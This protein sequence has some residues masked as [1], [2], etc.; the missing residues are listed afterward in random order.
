MPDPAHPADLVCFSHLRWD[1]VR[2]RPQHLLSRAAKQYRVLFIEEPVFVAPDGDAVASPRLDITL[3]PDGVSVVVP[4]LP[5]GLEGDALSFHLS[6]LIYALLAGRDPSSRVLWYYTPAAVDFSADLPAAV[7]VYDNM[8]ELSAFLGASPRLLAQESAL[9]AKAD[10]VFTGGMSL[11]A[12]KRHRH[13]SV[14]PFPS[15]IDVAH[16]AQALSHDG[17]E[18]ADQLE[19][20]HPRVGFFGVIDERM[21]RDLV[22]Q[23]ADQRPDWQFVILGP[24]VKID[25]AA[26]PRRPNLHWLGPK[27]YEALPHYLAGWDAGFMP[28]ALNEATR[29]ISPTKTPEFLAAGVPVVSTPITDVVT[30][31]GAKDLVKIADNAQDMARHLDGLLR[32]PRDLWRAAV[33]RQLSL[34]S[35]DKTWAGMHGLIQGIASAKARGRAISPVQPSRREAAISALAEPAHV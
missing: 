31:Y 22:A 9:F 26:L 3:R 12:A 15:S 8:D 6:Q 24:V 25:P 10:L 35:W 17:A 2:Q 16:F 28:F 7:T 14:H 4:L 23:L 30:P 27:S 13:H 33:K 18:P 20:P 34:S 29:F 5:Q 32:Q 19:I 11:Y 21:D 1:F